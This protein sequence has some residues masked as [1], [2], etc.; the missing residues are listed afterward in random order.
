MTDSR[1]DVI[2]IGYGPVGQS[3]ALMLG[4]RGRSVAV[5]ERWTKRYA[6]PRAVWIDHELY[7]GLS[8]KGIGEVLPAVSHRGPLYCWVNADWKQLLVIGWAAESIS[9]GAEV[10]FDDQH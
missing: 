3:L 4:R 10:D 9:R 6:L 1:Y 8:A 2:Q 5:V 7:R